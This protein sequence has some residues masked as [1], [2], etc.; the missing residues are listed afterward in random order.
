[1]KRALFLAAG[2]LAGCG[3]SD[4]TSSEP[5]AEPAG[6]APGKLVEAEAPAKPEAPAGVDA[7]YTALFAQLPDQAPSKD[8][9]WSQEK[10][11]LGRMLYFDKRLSKDGTVSCNSCHQLDKFGVDG[12]RPPSSR[13]RP[14]IGPR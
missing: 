1:M 11:D 10:A 12:E 14:G 13:R 3:S 6:S 8:H 7:K 4:S 9:P 2:L 5:A